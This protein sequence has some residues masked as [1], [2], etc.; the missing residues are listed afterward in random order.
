M[1]HRLIRGLIAPHVRGRMEPRIVDHC[2]ATGWTV[3]RVGQ[4]AYLH[5]D[6]AHLVMGVWARHDPAPA[7]A[8]R[9][10]RPSEAYVRRYRRTWAR[11]SWRR[12]LRTQTGQFWI[13]LPWWKWPEPRVYRW[14]PR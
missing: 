3:H 8:S 6:D 10:G 4:A 14:G 13:R 12:M 5:R 2:R 11:E 9:L 1:G 7:W